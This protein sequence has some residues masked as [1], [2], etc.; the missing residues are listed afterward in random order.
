MQMLKEDENVT[1]EFTTTGLVSELPDPTD[2]ESFAKDFPRLIKKQTQGAELFLNTALYA[3]K[4]LDPVN[5]VPVLRDQKRAIEK[6]AELRDNVDIKLG[7]L[8][9][10]RSDPSQWDYEEEQLD[11]K[12]VALNA[13]LTTIEDQAVRQIEDPI[14]TFE[15]KEPDIGRLLPLAIPTRGIPLLV[16]VGTRDWA[17]QGNAREWVG[18]DDGQRINSYAVAV[19]EPSDALT[20]ECRTC[21]LRDA[22]TGEVGYDVW[23]SAAISI[24]YGFLLL[25][26]EL[27]LV[28]ARST[29]FDIVYEV[30]LDNGAN[31]ERRNGKQLASSWWERS[32]DGLDSEAASESR[33]K[34][35]VTSGGVSGGQIC[36]APVGWP[37]APAAHQAHRNAIPT[38]TR[39]TGKVGSLRQRQ[40]MGKLPPRRRTNAELRSREYL[41]ESE[42]DK[43]IK[44]AEKVGRHGHRD[45]TLVLIAYRHALRVSE[46]VSLRWDAIDLS[47]GFVHVNRLKNGRDSTHPLSGRE[48]RALRR[49]KREYPDTPHV[50]VSERGANDVVE[51]AQDAHTQRTTSP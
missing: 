1:M 13:A 27:R 36:K 50:F 2:L 44:A 26:I 25:G 8:Q 46:L 35:Q 42:V 14:A 39:S 10:I 33:A 40:K 38:M 29:H 34:D 51:R 12:A 47:K 20:I 32:R 11:A 15:V 4:G 41:T 6:L 28:G 45:A 18:R 48:I 17:E 21:Y 37:C 24:D 43:L 19:K 22:K 30:W 5:P 3:N 16:T 23:H 31:G 49:L 9:Q 7:E